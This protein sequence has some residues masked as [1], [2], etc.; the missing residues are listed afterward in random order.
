MT[1]D[2]GDVQSI[3]TRSGE[4][5][6]GFALKD[7]TAQPLRFMTITYRT[8]SEAKAAREKILVAIANAIDVYI[9]G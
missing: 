9:A 1:I 2:I 5:G 8:H 3:S 6:W 7:S 4:T